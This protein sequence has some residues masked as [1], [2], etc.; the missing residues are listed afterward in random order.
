MDITQYDFEIKRHA[1][2]R[3]M[4]RN[5][6]P[7]MIEATLKGGNI[8]RFGK[9]NVKFIKDCK[10]FTVICV[11][12]MVGTKVKIFTIETKGEKK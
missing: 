11:G 8:E 4:E 2:I 1:F 6:T 3:A 9:N 7:D 5:V 10:K 12:E